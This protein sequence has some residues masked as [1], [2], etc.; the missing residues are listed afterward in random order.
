MITFFIYIK[1]ENT[2]LMPTEGRHARRRQ[3]ARNFLRRPLKSIW[4]DWMFQYHSQ[5]VINLACKYFYIHR[6]SLF[7]FVLGKKRKR[8]HFLTCQNINSSTLQTNWKATKK[9]NS[10]SWRREKIYKMFATTL[11][12]Q[13]PLRCKQGKLLYSIID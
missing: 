8:E 13:S 2:S 5:F 10:S 12:I 11:S 9:D 3:I 7:V 1:S 6:F 4:L